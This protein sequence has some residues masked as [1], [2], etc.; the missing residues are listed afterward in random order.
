MP[1]PDKRYNVRVEVEVTDME[2]G[3]FVSNVTEWAEVPMIGV[4]E[5]EKAQIAFLAKMNELGYDFLNSQA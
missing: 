3:P 4:L 5:I 1:T 2:G